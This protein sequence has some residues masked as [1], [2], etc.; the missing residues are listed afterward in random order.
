M[1]RGLFS[2]LT[3]LGLALC[4]LGAGCTQGPDEATIAASKKADLKIW[5]VIDDADVYDKII[6]DFHTLHPFTTIEYRRFRL[7]EYEDQL[8]NALAE[9]RGPDVFL[10]HNTWVGKYMPKIQPMPPT[11]KIAVQVVVGTLKKEVQYQLET[12]QS[13]TLRDFKNDYPDVVAKD[14]LR[15]INVSPTTDK[16]DF[17]QRVVGMP[18]SVDTLGMYVNKD[19]LNAAGIA[20]I[21]ETWDAFQEAV[22]D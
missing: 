12:Q 20:T 17:Q 22:K 13:V 9:D 7:E 8:L 2:R 4:V 15:T 19:L 18:I 14:F 16:R 11:T 21:P 1:Q 10:I 5:A 6:R 3:C